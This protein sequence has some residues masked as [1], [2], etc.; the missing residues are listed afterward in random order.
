MIAS[1][2]KGVRKWVLSYPIDQSANQ[3]NTFWVKFGNYLLE[4]NIQHFVR[5]CFE[6]VTYKNVHCSIVCNREKK[7]I[8]DPF[9]GEWLSW[10]VVTIMKYKGLQYIYGS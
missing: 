5:V 1:F 3:Y 9:T 8:E 2:S 4:C 7:P 10:G 6:G